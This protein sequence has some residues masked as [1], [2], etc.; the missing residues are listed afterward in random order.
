MAGKVTAHFHPDWRIP[1]QAMRETQAAMM[2]DARLGTHPIVQPIR[3]VLEA[4]QAFDEIT[5][6]K[7]MAVVTMLESMVG[8]AAFRSGV[9]RYIRKHAYGNTV[10]DDLWA[11]V[12]ATAAQPVSTVAHDFTL[13]AGVPLVRVSGSEHTIELRQDRFAT[14]ASGNQPTRWHVPVLERSLDS[15]RSWHGVI[16]R[17]LPASLDGGGAVVVNVSHRGYFRTLYA[18]ALFRSLIARFGD[19]TPE[20]QAGL[21]SDT[22]VMGYSGL[23]PLSDLVE[24]ARRVM[25]ET[26]AAVLRLV[27]DELRDL[28][29]RLDGLPG[30]A[31]LRDYAR[32]LLHPIFVRT[33]W[34][35]TATDSAATRRLRASVLAALSQMGDPQLIGEGRSRFA[36]L[37]ADPKS[38]PADLRE[39]V[40]AVV[41]ENANAAE[42]EQLHEMAR[43][44]DSF[45][46]KQRLYAMLGAARDPGLARRA[47]QLTLTDEVEVTLRPDI[48]REVAESHFP[49]AAFE[50]ASAHFQQVS[51]WLEPDSRN[52]FAPRLLM[53]S[54]DAAMIDKLRA[55]AGEHI[56]VDARKDA[57]VAEAAVAYNAEIRSRRLPGL[58]EWLQ[59]HR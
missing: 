16:S 42:W 52:Q 4:N 24:L 5:Y 53:R 15:G 35:A 27:S 23:E 38:F 19:L 40:L 10:S 21:L 28:D 45:I 11:E 59:T 50:F 2:M 34:T 43:H 22:Q 9:R 49:E 31:L 46:E 13:Q 56:P 12:D 7:G 1:L 30:Q 37:R 6:G 3:D 26:D 48:I 29:A 32:N 41:A 8:E 36:S 55:Y 25:P 33:G 44:T 39:S 51:Q 14:E 18:P 58:D 54:G 47:L 57:V 17:D 20:D